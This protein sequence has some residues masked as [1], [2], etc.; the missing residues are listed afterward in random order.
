M[1]FSGIALQDLQNGYYRLQR[2][3]I[4]RHTGKS[5]DQ[6]PPWG[7]VLSCED[8]ASLIRIFPQKLLHLGMFFI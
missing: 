7:N 1:C 2:K 8:I 4:Q 3:T 6:L 5:L